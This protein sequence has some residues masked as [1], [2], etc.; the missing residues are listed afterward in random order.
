M[1]KDDEDFWYITYKLYYLNK[2]NNLVNS[3]N[4]IPE[5]LLSRIY[6][7]KFGINGLPV[8]RTSEIYNVDYSVWENEWYFGTRR[9]GV[10]KMHGRKMFKIV[11][12]LVTFF[13][14]FR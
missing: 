12:F 6:L 5:G 10:S 8:K 13:H 7:A 4:Y 2:I 1:C 14:I 3:I 11:S 9:N